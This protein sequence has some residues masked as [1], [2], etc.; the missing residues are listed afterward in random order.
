MRRGDSVHF[1]PGVVTTDA[2]HQDVGP[3]LA[4]AYVV[5]RHIEADSF[6]IDT[7]DARQITRT[8]AFDII[9]YMIWLVS[10]PVPRL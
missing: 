4:T 10:P 9:R 3:S 2:W 1:G 5:M 8:L 6:P 7:R